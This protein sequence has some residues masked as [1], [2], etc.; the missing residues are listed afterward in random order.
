MQKRGIQTYIFAVQTAVFWTVFLL[1]LTLLGTVDALAQSQITTI[2]TSTTAAVDETTNVTS[3]SDTDNDI[4]PNTNYNVLYGQGDSITVASYTVSGIAT[5]FSN[6]VYPDTLILRRTDGSR[7][8]NIWYTL[9]DTNLNAGDP[10]GFDTSADPDEL[11]VDA[12]KV[13]EADAIYLTRNINAGYDNILVNDD[14]E[15]PNSQIQAQVERVD[16]LWYTGIVTCEPDN[17]VFPIIERGGNDEIK[18][19]AVLSLDENGDPASYSPLIDIEDADWPG[20]T[21]QGELY[22]N[23]LVLRRQ[24]IGANPIPLINFG[25]DT[26]DGAQLVQGVAVSFTEFGISANEIVYGYSLFAFDVNAVDHD[27]TD[28]T[29]FPSTTLAS[30]SGLDLVAGVAAAVAND[31]CLTTSTGP[32]GYKQALA[33]WLKANETAD[34]TTSTEGSS[35]TDWQDHWTGNHD[36]TTGI[37]APTY[38]N[39]SSTI[40]FNPT[41]DFTTSATSLGIADNTDFNI[42]TS[43]TNKGLNIAFRTASDISTR[44]VLYKQGGDT[45]GIIVYIESNEIIVSAW[46]RNNDGAG[47]PWNNGSNINVINSSI[48]A[49]TEYIVTLEQNGNTSVTGTLTAYLNGASFGPL[50]NVGLLFAHGVDV[51]IGASDATTQYDDGTDASTN[52]FDGEI[53]EFIYCNEPSNFALSQRNRIESYLAIKYG[54]T[55]DQ[56]SPYDY[57]D[58]DGVTVYDATNNASI[59]GYLEYNND[60]AGIAR[61]DGSELSQIAS[62]SENTGSIVT[63]DKGA[64]FGKDGTYLIWGNDGGA[65]T[66]QGTDVPPLINSRLTREW[67]VA[68]TNEAGNVSVSFDLTGLGFGSEASDFSL[69]I[70]SSSSNNVFTSARIITGG[71]IDGNVITFNNVNFADGEYFT[72]GTGFISCSPGDVSTNLTLWL[73]ADLGPSNTTDGGAVS[74]WEDKAGSNDASAPGAGDEPSYVANGLNYNPALDFQGGYN[75]AGVD[76]EELAGTAGFNSVGY[77]AV[78]VPDGNVNQASSLQAPIGFGGNTS[79]T[80]DLGCLCLGQFNTDVSGELVT[81]VIGSYNGTTSL[82]EWRRAVTG[83]TVYSGGNPLLFGVKD[84]SGGTSTEIFIDG[85]QMDDQTGFGTGNTFITSSNQ[86]YMVGNFNTGTTSDRDFSGKVTELISYSVRPTDAEHARIQSY[87]AIKYGIHLSVDTDGDATEGE[88]ITGSINEGDYVASDGTTFPWEYDATYSHDVAGFGRDDDSCLDQRQSMSQG[89]DDIVA[90]G[91]NTI[92][93]TNFDNTNALSADLTFLMWGNDDGATAFGSRTTGV[94]GIGSVTERMTRIW[95]VN[96]TGT[97]GNTTVSFDL[98]GLGYSTNAS[99]FTFIQSASPSLTSATTYTNG[100]LDGN[101]LTFTGINF[102]DE[103]YFTLGTAVSACGPGGITANLELWFKSNAGTSTTVDGASITTWEDQTSNN[104][105]ASET[106]LGGTTVIEPTY[107]TSEINFRPVIRIYDPGS[108]NSSFLETGSNTVSGDFTLIA[109]MK[110]GQN[111]GTQGNF[112]E[113]PAIIGASTTSGTGL[114]DYGLGMESG[115]IILNASSGDAFDVE[116]TNTFNDSNPHLVMAT[117]VQSSGAL[118]IFVDGNSEGTGTAGATLSL[119]EPGSFGIGNHSTE[120]VEAQFNGDIAEIIV[121]SGALSAADRDNVESYL[122]LK[123]GITLSNSG[124]GTAG[125]YE[126]S[127]NTLIWDASALSTYH[128]DVA[129]IGRDDGSCMNQLKARSQNSDGIVTMEIDNLTTDASF[130]IWGNDNEAFEE[131][132]NKERPETIDSR[133]KRE[134]IIEENGTVGTVSITFD[135][136]SIDGP[137]GVGTN[138]YNLLRLMTDPTDS[139]FSSGVTLTSPSSFDASAMTVT[140]EFDFTDGMYYTLGSLEN[141]ALP[142]TLT[143]FDARAIDNEQVLIEWATIQEE[144]N[145]YFTI[146]RSPD[147]LRYTS[148][149]HLDGAGNSTSLREYSYRDIDPLDGQ[150]FYRLK[151]TDFGGDFSYSPVVRVVLDLEEKIGITLSPNPVSMGEKVRIG[152]QIKENKRVEFAFISANGVILRTEEKTLIASEEYVEIS[153]S[154]LNRGLHILRM[155]DEQQ[156][157]ISVKVLVR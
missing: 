114:L 79:V 134:W 67:R 49:N 72:L 118:E 65:T 19:A 126:S 150:A 132:G 111:A 43:Y 13:S 1:T 84:N 7:F 39:T 59:G 106:N 88:T 38:R 54:I 122:A 42:A 138:N 136:S 142:I 51:Q 99:D 105:D 62:R 37:A 74:T 69:L 86:D 50:N 12:S 119:S 125:D 10:D 83:G 6:F 144:N 152:Y 80:S 18:I 45:R 76:D 48:S 147:G 98:T 157:V 55:L 60:I 133:L 3:P 81:H 8:V 71:T 73:K 14:D 128:N 120:Q 66:T 154:G 137:E 141:A 116:T 151:Q 68:E 87:L 64:T 11:H 16:V 139:D 149:A 146:E 115:Q 131:P 53:S 21:T 33:T 92:E 44:Q 26:G 140:F 145:A 15:A 4:V 23:F 31:D 156:R 121:Y 109:L 100:T 29:T 35:V 124:G 5:A 34:V 143:H 102:S 46:N 101:I 123:Y 107:E 41:V 77:Y 75:D 30:D 85:E 52:S 104:N 91:N 127:A 78:V 103:D 25:V 117:R 130:M 22:N 32:G 47:S 36:A 28:P 108:N 17:A 155:L 61:D 63:M 148:I 56:T 20:G 82:Q 93:D 135:L 97:V 129:G 112:A 27:L 57:L 9:I 2:T 95:H 90:I 40:N 70:A 113:T 110:S 153:T 24:T 58:S 94:S 89:T 96:E